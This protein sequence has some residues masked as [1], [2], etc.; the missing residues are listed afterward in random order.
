D[1][2]AGRQQEEDGSHHDGRPEPLGGGDRAAEEPV[3][4][5]GER[6]QHPDAREPV[7]A[8]AGF[9]QRVD[10]EGPAE[11]AAEDDGAEAEAEEKSADDDGGGDRVAAEAVPEGPLPHHLVDEAREPEQA[12]RSAMP[13]GRDTRAIIAS[14]PRPPRPSGSTQR[15]ARCRPGGPS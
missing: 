5:P 13:A 2:D 12:T 9:D 14:A 15:V 4:D 1:Q 6:R 7:A 11:P 8:D 3:E 10:R